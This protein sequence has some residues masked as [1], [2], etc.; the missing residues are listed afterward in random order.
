MF[1]TLLIGVLL[2]ATSSLPFA[3][4]LTIV[5]AL[6]LAA[7]LVLERYFSDDERS[8]FF[9]ETWDLARKIFPLLIVGTFITGVI[10]YFLPVD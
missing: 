1:L 2:S 3:L 4:K 7:A 9:G 5:A 6:V 8:V 10:G